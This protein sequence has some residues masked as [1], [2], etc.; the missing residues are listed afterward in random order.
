MQTYIIRRLIQVV[1]VLIIV[2]L[3][4]FFLMRL[5]PGDP[6]LMYISQDEYLA[7]KTSAEEID[8]LRHQFGLDKP[9]LVQYGDWMAG[10]F[11]GD[12]G[13]SIIRGTKVTWEIGRSLPITLHLTALAMTISIIIG[14]PLGIISAVRR[15][16]WMDT[17]ATTLA[18]IGI[19]APVFW[20]GILLIY[21]FGLFLEWLP[22]Y[23][24]TSPFEDFGLNLRELVMPVFC[25][26]IFPLAGLAR[27][28]RSAMLEVIRQDYIRTAF[29]K[30]LKEHTVITRH[31]LKNG[32]IP[33]VTMLGMM[34]RR[35]FGGQVL[36]ET[37]FNIP[38]MSGL[39]VTAIMTQDYQV[40]Q[41]VLLMMAI[42]VTLASLLVDLSYG[43]LD[44]RI[45]Y[46]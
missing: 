38:G 26:S 39:A 44:P 5:L 21:L 23:G 19:T 4:V 6:V 7:A 1:F 34:I 3:I 25:L 12:F 41:G 13:E 46:G 16:T 14:I 15:G 24:Y 11:R 32:L 45:R 8:A 9:I 35:V 43:W 10:V 22:V 20:V 30:G 29:A 31:A 33:V 17:L 27:Q 40:V 2:T 28:T 18:N 42:A 36:V 37:V